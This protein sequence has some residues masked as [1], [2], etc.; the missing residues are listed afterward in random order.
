MLATEETDTS[1]HESNLRIIKK[2]YPFSFVSRMFVRKSGVHAGCRRASLRLHSQTRIFLSARTRYLFISFGNVD[3]ARVGVTTLIH[4]V[5][6]VLNRIHFVLCLHK[7]Q[8]PLHCRAHV[9]C[10]YCP[11][12][13][14]WTTGTR[15]S[16]SKHTAHSQCGIVWMC[17]PS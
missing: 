4:P 10:R 7:G 1:A 13:V 2:H 17:L 12:C 14:H 9:K 11:H 5:F 15:S 16:S 6:P 3:I 8:R